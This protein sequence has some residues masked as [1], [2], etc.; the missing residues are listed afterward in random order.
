MSRE[1]RALPPGWCTA[2]LDAISQVRLGRQRSPQNHEGPNMRPYLRAANLTWRGIDVGDVKEMNF[3]DAETA[4][5]RLADGDILL[6]EASGSAKEVG[7]PGVW[8]SQ[9]PGDMC[10]QNTLLRVRPEDGINSDYLYYRL[11]H[12]CLRGG[13]SESSRGV[14]I[15]HLG[16]AGLAS[17]T[18][19]VP[20]TM[21]QERIAGALETQLALLERLSQDIRVLT[22]RTNL[23]ASRVLADILARESSPMTKLKTV[24]LSPLSN[25]RS[26]PTRDG[27]FPVLRLTALRSGNVDL[28]QSKD[29]D[30]TADDARPWLVQRGDFFV[31]RGNGSLHLV[32]RGGLVEHDP[33][34][35]AFPDTMIRVRADEE[36]CR[37]R[38][39]RLVWDSP[40]VRRQV[41]ARAR[42]TAGIYKVNQSQLENIDVPLP[43]LDIQDQIVEEVEYVIEGLAPCVGGLRLLGLRLETLRKGLLRDAFAGRSVPQDPTDGPADLILKRIEEERQAS[44]ATARA[45]KPRTVRTRTHKT[46]EPAK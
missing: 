42:T 35:V 6:N 41:E 11:L 19:D 28:A 10:F 1:P 22:A 37:A 17:L 13:F 36:V 29:G 20:P 3:T 16:A 32:G 21:E 25:G 24:L 31:A 7:K 4:T 43:G 14:G 23:V 38:Y 44:A 39:L 26:V 40:I 45:V 30:W 12:E 27:G 33:R 34:P 18:V 9:L 5:Y 15:H 8:R 46:Q 2:R